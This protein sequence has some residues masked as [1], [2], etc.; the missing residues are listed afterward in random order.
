MAPMTRTRMRRLMRRAQRV[1][2]PLRLTLG[3]ALVVGGVLG[4]LPVV[5]FWML[6]LGLLVLSLDLPAARRLH[7]RL[8]RKVRAWW[9]RLRRRRRA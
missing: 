2:R 9:R 4:F 1:S 7:S 3:V 6:P 8:R 5:G